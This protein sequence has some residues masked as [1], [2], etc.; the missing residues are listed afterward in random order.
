LLYDP[1]TAGGMLISVAEDSSSALLQRLK[2]T[3]PLAKVI[4]RVVPK[5]SHS[6]MVKSV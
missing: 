6:I 3:Y 1:Q 5:A 2:V 4:G